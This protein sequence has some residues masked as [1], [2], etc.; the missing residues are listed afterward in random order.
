MKSILTVATMKTMWWTLGSVHPT[1]A[2]CWFLKSLKVLKI[3]VNSLYW[4]IPNIYKYMYQHCTVFINSCQR[5]I[6]T[7]GHYEIIYN[8]SINPTHWKKAR[9]WTKW[10]DSRLSIAVSIT[11]LYYENEILDKRIMIK[12]ISHITI[13]DIL[14]LT[15]S[16]WYLVFTIPIFVDPAESCDF[17]FSADTLL[18]RY[19]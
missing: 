14:Y 7:C 19:L 13:F 17:I 9:G 18:R 2:I 5:R 3:I 8:N 4:F 11:V 6:K 10:T 16:Y 12:K 1:F 15:S